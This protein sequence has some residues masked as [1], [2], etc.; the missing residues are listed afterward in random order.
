MA[1]LDTAAVFLADLS[2]ALPIA[3]ELDFVQVSRYRDGRAAGG[4]PSVRLVKDLGIPPG[5][6]DVVVVD[7]I[8]DTGL[9][10]NHVL[11]TLALRRPRTLAAV[12]LLDRPHRRLVD[13]LPI[14]HVGFTVPDELLAGYRLGVSERTRAHPDLRLVRSDR[15]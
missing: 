4:T 12:V 2:R 14:R 8:V 15:K 3:H 13:G 1:P 6:R 11:R 5:G 7:T 10:L 9:T